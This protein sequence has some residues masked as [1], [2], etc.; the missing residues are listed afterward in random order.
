MIK[1]SLAVKEQLQ[2]ATYFG[3]K[4]LFS[5]KTNSKAQFVTI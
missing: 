5:L 4:R 2:F 3:S 1:T